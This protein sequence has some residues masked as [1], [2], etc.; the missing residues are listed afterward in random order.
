MKGVRIVQLILLVLVAVYLWLFHSA[1]PDMVELPLTRAFLP[2]LPV[3]F[4]VIAALLIGW[5]IGFVPGRI[6]LWRKNRELRRLNKELAELRQRPEAPTNV[7]QTGTYYPAPEVPVIPDRRDTEFGASAR[8]DT[9][10]DP[11]EAA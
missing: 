5:L 3:G 1:N 4:V 6:L 2:Q 10:L 8:Q 11:D 9:D 7:Y